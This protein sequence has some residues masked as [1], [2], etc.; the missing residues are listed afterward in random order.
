MKFNNSERR[1][2]SFYL[3]AILSLLPS[4]KSHSADAKS[5]EEI[6]IAETV[7][8]AS[9]I[10]TSTIGSV[11]YA[12]VL[13][14]EELAKGATVGLGEVL[15]DTLGVSTTDFGGAVS[16]PTIRGL[17]GDRVKVLSNGART[18]DVSGLGADHSMDV[19]LFNVEQIGVWAQPLCS[20]QMA[21]SAAL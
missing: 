1:S 9:L 11:G 4:V 2:T 20:T 18:R 5:A 17:T 19:D 15:D 13:N 8:T 10:G 21:P 7:V 16:R 12:N 14:R 6:Q 3:G